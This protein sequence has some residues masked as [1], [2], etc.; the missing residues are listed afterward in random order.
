MGW[1]RD[2][3][4]LEGFKDGSDW[5][6]ERGKAFGNQVGKGCACPEKSVIDLGG[7]QTL[8]R[9]RQCGQDKG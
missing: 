1:G 6:A 5:P 3:Y 8:G 2:E 9:K 7:E 4:R